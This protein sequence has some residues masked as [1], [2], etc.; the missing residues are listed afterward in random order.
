MRLES[1]SNPG[2]TLARTISSAKGT[3]FQEPD[4]LDNS[5]NDQESGKSN[6]PRD[7]GTQHGIPAKQ[8]HQRFL[9]VRDDDV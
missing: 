5:V 8:R 6:P 9:G 1:I 3:F 2:N 7:N 4:V